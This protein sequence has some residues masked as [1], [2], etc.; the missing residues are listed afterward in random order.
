[1]TE[2]V[3]LKYFMIFFFWP[4]FW[5]PSFKFTL[6]SIIQWCLYFFQNNLECNDGYYGQDC[7]LPCKYPR[8][9]EK[10]QQT[11][12]CMPFK[13][14][15]LYGCENITGIAH[16]TD[17]LIKN[18]CCRKSVLFPLD[19]HSLTIESDVFFIQP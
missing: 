16:Y 19:H 12:N 13:C 7:I 14:N 11:C 15:N 18:L 1:M 4:Q 5:L 6:I 9:G 3:L 8:Y 2:V 10:C 17:F